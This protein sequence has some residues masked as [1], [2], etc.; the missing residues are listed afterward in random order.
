MIDA[1]SL[2]TSKSTNNPKYLAGEQ[3][4]SRRLIYVA[5]TR[6][7]THLVA[8]ISDLNAFPSLS[9]EIRNQWRSLVESLKDSPFSSDDPTCEWP[10]R[11]AV[12]P[13]RPIYRPRDADSITYVE[14]SLMPPIDERRRRWSYSTLHHDGGDPA[15]D[16][17]ADAIDSAYEGGSRSEVAD[18]DTPLVSSIAFAGLRG[19]VL[20]NAVHEVMEHVVGSVS[21]RDADQLRDIVAARLTRYRLVAQPTSPVV[22]DIVRDVQTALQHSLGPLF[23]NQSLDDYVGEAQRV[24]T[25]M[26]FTLGISPS[27]ASLPRD[28][29]RDIGEMA[30]NLDPS[31]PYREFFEQLRDASS[32]EPRLYEGVL[33]GSIDLVARVGDDQPRYVIVD[34]KTNTLKQSAT[35]SPSDLVP[36]MMASSYPLQALLYGVALHR[37]LRSR[38][39]NYDPAANLGGALYYYVRG[40]V[41]TP[42]TLDAGLASWQPDASLFTTVS[43]LLSSRV[44][45]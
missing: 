23:L 28:R 22:D 35:Y 8:W 29:L 19:P 38:L 10:T 14:P 26:R 40:P 42:E 25:E 24:A 34:Y 39:T 33:T 3:A 27:E 1:E 43:D 13:G 21:S 37:Y 36:E 9:G 31:G 5:L 16:K 20:G 18:D 12:S 2:V 6:A 4:E 11:S 45:S 30:V 7:T 32:F 17:S 44:A 41:E 15:S